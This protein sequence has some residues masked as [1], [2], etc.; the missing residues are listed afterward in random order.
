MKERIDILL[1]ERG[2]AESRTKAQWLIRNG[3]IFVNS[4]IISKPSKRFEKFIEIRLLK[5][6]PYVGRGGIKLEKA[7]E[8]FSIDVKKKVCV[9]IGASVGGFTD[10][11]IKKGA[12]KVYAIDTATNLL[13]TS[14]LNET[15]QDKIIPI[16]GV[17][18]RNSLPIDELVD[19]CTIDIT[20]TSLREVLPNVKNLLRK[21]GDI[22]ALVK[23]LFEIDFHTQEKFRRINNSNQLSKILIELIQWLKHN[24]FFIYGITKST[25][26]EKKGSKEFFLHLKL[27]KSSFDLDYKELI[28]DMLI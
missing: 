26:L 4:K 14:L 1:V 16:S 3:Y 5:E 17:D 6:F 18:A 20:F 27:K 15:L 12:L 23:P 21:E 10:C 25:Q 11:L 13:H 7:I 24:D 8:D 28:R 9:D 19:L 22:L 2:L